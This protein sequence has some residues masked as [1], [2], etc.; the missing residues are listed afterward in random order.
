MAVVLTSMSILQLWHPDRHRG[1]LESVR[2]FQQ[3]QHAYE[4]EEPL[5]ARTLL[6]MW[7]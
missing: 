7:L 2:R 3:I 4:G 6:L 5:L 1:N